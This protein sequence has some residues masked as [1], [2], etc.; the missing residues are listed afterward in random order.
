MRRRVDERQLPNA[1]LMARILVIDDHDLVR[2]SVKAMVERGGHDVSVAADGRDGLKQLRAERFDLII[3]DILMPETDG[4]EIVKD[5]RK[6]S[7]TV[8]II[9]MSGGPSG[10]LLSWSATAD[11]LKMARLLGA[12]R[13]IEK[14]FGGAQLLALIAECLL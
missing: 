7:G 6:A 2:Q 10:R 5:L 8:P 1:L 11:Y 12:T 9:A 14:P 4:L 3:T 13:T